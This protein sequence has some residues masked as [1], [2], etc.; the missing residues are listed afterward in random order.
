MTKNEA[1]RMAIDTIQW[2]RSKDNLNINKESL[3]EITCKEALEI[4]NEIVPD[5]E[6]L[7]IAKKFNIFAKVSAGGQ[8]MSSTN[9]ESLILGFASAIALYTKDEK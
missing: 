8:S 5:D 9:G 4:K 6:V 1:L 2:M 7:R 3:A